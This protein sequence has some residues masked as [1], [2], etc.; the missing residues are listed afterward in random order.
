MICGPN[1]AGGRLNAFAL[2][3]YI[4]GPLAQF[5]DDLRRDL[6]PACVPHAHVTILPPRP[7]STEPHRAAAHA[8][9]LLQDFAPFVVEAAEIGV[10][11]VTDVV[12]IEIGQGS[13]E[14]RR[15]HELL[16]TGPLEFQEPF[17]YHPHITVAQ[18]LASD[19]LTG[20]LERAKESW[21]GTAHPR[22]F[23]LDV[24]TFVQN[25][26]PNV[27]VDLEEFRLGAVAQ[28]L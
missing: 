18:D 1:G 12:Y 7:I 22:R 11:P 16:N 28:V 8:R 27:W 25:A 3:S 21:K 4:P 2:V 24:A 20:I 19:D 10:F 14:L 23:L 26:I 17:D 15:L 6:V 5:L 13:D 9:T